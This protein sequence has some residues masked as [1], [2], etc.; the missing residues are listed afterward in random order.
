MR[1][2][3]DI[4]AIP[5]IPFIGGSQTTKRQR[6]THKRVWPERQ[7]QRHWDG[8][9]CESWLESFNGGPVFKQHEAFLFQAATANQAETDRCWNA[10]VGNGSEESACGWCK[11]KTDGETAATFRARKRERR[12]APA[13]AVRSGRGWWD[14]TGYLWRGG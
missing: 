2:Q 4:S 3:N 6:C 10:I 8:P 1:C 9:S 13:M 14:V 11:D 12:S 5:V 7:G